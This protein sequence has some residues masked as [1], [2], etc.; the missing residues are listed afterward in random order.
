MKIYRFYRKVSFKRYLFRQSLEVSAILERQIF[1]RQVVVICNVELSGC[2]L[3]VR[4]NILLAVTFGF[5]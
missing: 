2:V 5:E 3:E 4:S 1:C